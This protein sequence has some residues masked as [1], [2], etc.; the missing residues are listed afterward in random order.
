[1]YT[2]RP[3]QQKAVDSAMQYIEKHWANLRPGVLELCTGAG[4]SIIIS[5]LCRRLDKKVLILQPSVEILRQNVEKLE[6]YGI[7]DIGIYS[8]SADS[9]TVGQYTYATVGS[10]TSCLELFKDV[11]VILIDECHANLDPKNKNNQYFKVIDYIKP[12]AVIGL[13]AT[14][15]RNVITTTKSKY[16]GF[17]T[18]ET[19]L[20]ALT[21]IP[22]FFWKSIITQV[23]L[24]DLIAERYLM[25]PRYVMWPIDTSLLKPN[26]T[27]AEFTEKSVEQ[28]MKTTLDKIVGSIDQVSEFYQEINIIPKTLT[29]VPSIASAEML[30][31]LFAANGY[32]SVVVTG[33]MSKK[34]RQAIIKDYKKPDG[35]SHVINVGTLTTGFDVPSINVVLLARPTLSASLYVQMVGRLL[36]IDPSCEIDKQDALL[37]DFGGNVERFGP[38]EDIQVGLEEGST[39]LHVVNSAKGVISDK[40]I[41]S[42]MIE[43]RK[44]ESEE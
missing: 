1:M 16:S 15:Y 10:I 40:K 36:R 17:V 28:F 25:E 12:K 34:D 9:R 2:L 27:G 30:N 14:P 13:T 7:T 20:R 3:Y 18:S 44:K 41:S 4:K 35:I 5:E 32:K 29:F 22:N 11:E 37:I 26:S 21:R 6:S 42:V 31:E 33:E 19:K 38:A 43:V 39:F 24:K 23:T 8:A